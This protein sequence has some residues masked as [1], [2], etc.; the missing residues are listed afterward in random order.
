MQGIR[1]PAFRGPANRRPADR[2]PARSRSRRRHRPNLAVAEQ[3]N[4]GTMSVG[5]GEFRKFIQPFIDTIGDDLA[6][7]G[8]SVGG[9]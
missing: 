2:Q 9:C 1:G 6:F 4:R 8:L 3:L 7:E 5:A